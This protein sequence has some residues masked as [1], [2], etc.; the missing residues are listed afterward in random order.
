MRCGLRTADSDEHNYCRHSSTAQMG[1]SD[2]RCCLLTLKDG[3]VVTSCSL[4][5]LLSA[6]GVC[7]GLCVLV[8]EG[9]KN[10]QNLPVRTY[11]VRP[12]G[13]NPG[14]RLINSQ[15]KKNFERLP[16]ELQWS[17]GAQTSTNVSGRASRTGVLSVSPKSAR[18]KR[19]VRKKTKNSQIYI[20]IQGSP[21][22]SGMLPA[23]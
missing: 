15:R 3:S 13:E 18:T 20:Y 16:R 4:H 11:R 2:A 10:R 8:R 9:N 22:G 5:V 12:H 1:V 6:C 14:N 17:D 21:S 19:Y 23:G 7:P